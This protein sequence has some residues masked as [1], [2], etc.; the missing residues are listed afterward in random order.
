MHATS[1]SHILPVV[2]VG[3][4]G[5]PHNGGYNVMADLCIYCSLCLQLDNSTV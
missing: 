1:G 5:G 4:K 2:F 3:Q